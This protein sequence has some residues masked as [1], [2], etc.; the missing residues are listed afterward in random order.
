[1]AQEKTLSV[2][3]TYSEL[4]LLLRATH[5]GTAELMV[6]DDEDATE[7]VETFDA[8][9]QKVSDRLNEVDAIARHVA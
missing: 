7:I 8:I 9:R 2:R 4:E 6:H 1:M 5:S 3:L